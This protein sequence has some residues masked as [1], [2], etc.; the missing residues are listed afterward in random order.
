MNILWFPLLL[1]ALFVSPVGAQT[2]AVRLKINTESWLG[3]TPIDLMAE[4][5][6]C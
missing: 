5:T 3:T 1:L 4:I 2:V 6:V